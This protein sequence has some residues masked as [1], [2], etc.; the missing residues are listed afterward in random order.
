MFVVN[1]YLSP[2]CSTICYGQERSEAFFRPSQVGLF[3]QVGHSDFWSHQ[4]FAQPWLNLMRYNSTILELYSQVQSSLLIFWCRLDQTTWTGPKWAS[5][6]KKTFLEGSIYDRPRRKKWQIVIHIRFW[7]GRWGWLS[8]SAKVRLLLALECKNFACFAFILYGL[9][10]NKYF[11]QIRTIHSH[12]S[13]LTLSHPGLKL[14]L[15]NIFQQEQL[16]FL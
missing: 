10:I 5:K 1:L 3:H 12:G 4:G 9:K 14:S 8:A 6:W 11:S 7:E 16:D 13:A 2:S 15:L